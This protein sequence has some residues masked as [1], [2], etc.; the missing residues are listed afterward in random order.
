MHLF[1]IKNY[2]ARRNPPISVTDLEM[3]RN[4][5][6]LR[7]GIKGLYMPYLLNLAS[8]MVFSSGLGQ[9]MYLFTV[10]ECLKWCNQTLDNQIQ[11]HAVLSLDSAALG[12][13]DNIFPRVRHTQKCSEI[14]I[15]LF[16]YP[17]NN[18]CCYFKLNLFRRNYS[19][20]KKNYTGCFSQQRL[21][22]L[23]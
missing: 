13:T 10:R 18:N 20:K 11:I 23:G 12:D 1:L 16:N 3:I 17:L 8:L 6:S 14:R 4:L 15:L 9:K 22:S 21:N 19:Y 5:A 7:S 2:Q